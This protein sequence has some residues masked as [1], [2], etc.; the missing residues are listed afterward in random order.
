MAHN[1]PPHQ[2]L[3][4]LQIQLFSNLVLKEST[5]SLLL[6]AVTEHS[7]CK[8]RFFLFTE[9]HKLRL[10]INKKYCLPT[11]N[12]RTVTCIKT[13]TLL[14]GEKVFLSSQFQ[15]ISASANGGGNFVSSHN[16]ERY[17]N[18]LTL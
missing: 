14:T 7:N 2:D 1:E 8:S 10:P 6:L 18:I 15:N 11:V 3:R 13:D 9:I 12:S 16:L 5:K 17:A 4:C